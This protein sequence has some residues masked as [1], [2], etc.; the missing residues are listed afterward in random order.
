MY[1]KFIYTYMYVHFFE[2]L[3]SGVRHNCT[4]LTINIV[5]IAKTLGDADLKKEVFVMFFMIVRCKTLF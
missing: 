1:N 4:V 2:C 5:I 3:I